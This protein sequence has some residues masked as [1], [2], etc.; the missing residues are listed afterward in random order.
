MPI[1]TQYQTVIPYLIINNALDFLDFMQNL[2]DAEIV[3]KHMHNE[4]TLMHAELKVGNATIMCGAA[5]AEWQPLNSSLF[6]YVDDADASYAKALELG[7][8]SIMELSN[9]NYGR[10]CGVKDVY[11]NIW[12]ITSI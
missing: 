11:G 4:T 9:Q 8:T 7:C 1:P 2:F 12:W 6:I 5:S 10:T 3:S